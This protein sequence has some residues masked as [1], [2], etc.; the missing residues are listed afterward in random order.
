[1]QG[2]AAYF[3]FFCG[4]NDDDNDNNEDD[5]YDDDEEEEEN[6]RIFSLSFLS[7]SMQN[8]D[9]PLMSAC[10]NDGG[11]IEKIEMASLL[12]KYDANVNAV[13]KVRT[14]TVS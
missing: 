1:M 12:L 13:N 14:V 9:S 3:Y 8:D 6:D 4:V 2:E 5:N 7:Y 11:Q 10:K